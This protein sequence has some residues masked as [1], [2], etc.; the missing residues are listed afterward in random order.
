M[1]ES[2]SDLITLNIGKYGA[3]PAESHTSISNVNINGNGG[4]SILGKMKTKLT[5]SNNVDDGAGTPPGHL[6]NTV[7]YL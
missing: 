3:L 6:S 7:V 5:G 4:S 2:A 1:I